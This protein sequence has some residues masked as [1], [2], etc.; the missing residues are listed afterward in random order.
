MI[1]Q[2]TITTTTTVL[3]PSYRSTC[4]SRHLQL[5]DF[6]G[7]KFYWPHA[8][9]EGKQCI[10]IGERMLEFSST[11]LST[12]SP[13]HIVLNAT[14]YKKSDR[15]WTTVHRVPVPGSHTMHVLPVCW[16]VLAA[17]WMWKQAVGMIHCV[18]M[19][20]PRQSVVSTVV[21]V[22]VGLPMQCSHNHPTHHTHPHSAAYNTTHRAI[23]ASTVI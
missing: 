2:N 19:A 5:Q 1:V 8:L 18:G 15:L 7:A 17:V 20:E 9:A 11:V 6:V 3:Q 13:Y 10:R 21:V 23:T 12:L 4:I 14:E 16:S 22:V